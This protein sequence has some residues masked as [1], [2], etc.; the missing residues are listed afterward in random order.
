[1]HGNDTKEWLARRVLGS[2]IA[3]K[4]SAVSNI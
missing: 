2:S 1:L 4:N 3:A